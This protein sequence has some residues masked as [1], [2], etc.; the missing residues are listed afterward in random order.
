MV[1]IIVY[2][3]EREC[4]LIM[5]INADFAIIAINSHLVLSDSALKNVG[6]DLFFHR[7]NVMMGIL[8]TTMGAQAPAKLNLGGNVQSQI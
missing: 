5:K 8:K 4:T 1:I 3:V 6:R 7:L 2:L